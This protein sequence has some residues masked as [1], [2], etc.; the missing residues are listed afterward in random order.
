MRITSA[1]DKGARADNLPKLG[2]TPAPLL[3]FPIGVL[4]QS[5]ISH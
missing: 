5:N 3:L 1:R 2:A 4:A